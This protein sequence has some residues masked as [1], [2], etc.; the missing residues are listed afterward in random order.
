MTKSALNIF[1]FDRF[2]LDPN[3]RVLF[4]DGRPLTLP[5]KVF[6]TLLLL[7]E[8]QGQVVVKED[9]FSRVWSDA[10]VEESNLTWNIH[11]I[12]KSLG[13]T[14]KRRF[15]AT[16]P[17]VGF[18]F[19][20]TVR[21]V[22]P[23]QVAS[24][25]SVRA[26]KKNFAAEE[27]PSIAVLPFLNIG[28][29]SE[30]E[31]LSD[32]LTEEV[33]DVLARIKGLWVAAR[34]SSFAF[35]GKDVDI[36][37][38]ADVLG[39]TFL[40]EGSVRKS[41]RKVRISARLFGVNQGYIWTDVFESQTENIFDLQENIARSVADNLRVNLG[42]GLTSIPSHRKAP[43]A[44]AYNYQLLGRYFWN[45]R[46][47][48]AFRKAVQNFESA[49]R[50]EPRYALAH[51]GIADVFNALGLYRMMPSREAFSKAKQAAQMALEIEPDLAEAHTAMGIVSTWL[52]WD[53]N[54][55]EEHFLRA[56]AAKPNYA[57]AHQWYALSLP[58]VDRIK[59]GI[60]EMC[61]AVQLEPLS[62]GINATLAWMYY[63]GR[64]NDRA[65]Q[66]ALITLERDQ[67]FGL[68]KYYLGLAY[69]QKN[70][71]SEAIAALT[72]LKAAAHNASARLS[73][74][75]FVHARAGEREEATRYLSELRHLSATQHVSAYDMAL[76]Y[77][78]LNDVDN[79]FEWLDRSI[80]ERGWL[81][82]LTVEPMF[83][84]LRED[85]RFKRLAAKL[86][87]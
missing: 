34:T 59:D 84:G 50:L 1:E 26:A 36:R 73:A 82:Y 20:E 21:V 43:N 27:I 45:Q 64:D 19:E 16:I 11:T 25:T 22:S 49:L 79:A 7:V 67:Q 76:I 6:Q 14:P 70:Q 63:T 37:T 85:H 4:K 15:I 81:N 41:A 77:V 44:D 87:T 3:Q 60:E 65:I 2:R 8:N 53:W 18:R 51:A 46:T 9:F 80:E 31:Y 78:G 48:D 35:R 38:I 29:N 47:P 61:T 56:L 75:G 5:P 74:L 30:N 52:D 42:V 10:V 62:L 12:R 54:T 24:G 55:G 13:E 69:A 57:T 72:E 58:I 28:G 17:K 83:D 68:A 23:S 33:I 71:F 86:H 40:I 66:Q 32:G 39:V